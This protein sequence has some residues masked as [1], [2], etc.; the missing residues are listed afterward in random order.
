M[1]QDNC[2]LVVNFDAENIIF[3]DPNFDNILN[4]LILIGKRY[5]FRMQI[6]KKMPSLIMFLKLVKLTY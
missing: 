5:L 4:E 1:L 2:E 6:E 3:G